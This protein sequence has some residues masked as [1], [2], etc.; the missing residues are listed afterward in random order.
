MA[1]TPRAF[2]RIPF[3]PV[4]EY[5]T[6][7]ADMQNALDRADWVGYGCTGEFPHNAG[8]LEEKIDEEQDRKI[9]KGPGY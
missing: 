8:S 1:R 5:E 6:T 7:F 2:I 9:V 4:E 3:T